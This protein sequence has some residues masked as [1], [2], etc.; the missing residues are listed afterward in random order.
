L[1][2]RVLIGELHLAKQAG[3]LTDDSGEES[4]FISKPSV[5]LPLPFEPTTAIRSPGVTVS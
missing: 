4:P 2:D 1:A 5:D 3:A